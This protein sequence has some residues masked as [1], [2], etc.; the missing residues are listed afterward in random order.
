MRQNKRRPPHQSA[1]AKALW[2]ER[3]QHISEAGR[4]EC[5]YRAGILG[6]LV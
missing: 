4:K 5:A 3:A 6:E 1:Y 2:Q